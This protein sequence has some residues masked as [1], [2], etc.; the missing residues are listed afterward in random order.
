VL[1]GPT[2]VG[3]TAVALALA[4]HWPLEVISAGSRPVYSGLA[5]APAQAS[6]RERESVPR[7]LLCAAA[8][9]A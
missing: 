8:A 3:K 5:I 6:R 4:A 2:G 7:H 9:G 1:V